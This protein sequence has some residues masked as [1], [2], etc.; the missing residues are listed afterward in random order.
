MV[1]PV[2][3]IERLNGA[4]LNTTDASAISERQAIVD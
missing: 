2:V 1:M 3:V 4:S